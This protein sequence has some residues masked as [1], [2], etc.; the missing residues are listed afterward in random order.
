MTMK[1]QGTF[2][3]PDDEKKNEIRHG[4]TKFET[5]GIDLR[6]TQFICVCNTDLS[7]YLYMGTKYD[8]GRDK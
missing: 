2:L 3:S 1:N 5:K 6:I 7:V 8:L 4:K